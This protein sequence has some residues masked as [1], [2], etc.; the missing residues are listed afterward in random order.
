ML[1]M[2][3]KTG[4]IIPMITKEIKYTNYMTGEEQ[5][6]KAS[7]HLNK[8]DMLRLIARS[9]KKT[10]EEHVQDIVDREDADELFDFIEEVIGL[11]YGV[12]SEDGRTFARDKEQRKAFINS[13]PYAELLASFVV[14]Q[15]T[16][17]EFFRGVFGVK[18]S[19]IPEAVLSGKKV[20]TKRKS[21]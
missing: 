3:K 12:R 18:E 11:S 14:D 15:D 4:G 13:E 16:A 8:A 5:T 9:G 6:E 20:A 19:A 17:A 2:I 21:K 1:K 10:W 7:F